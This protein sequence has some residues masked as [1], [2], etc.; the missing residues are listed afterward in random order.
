[1]RRTI[2]SN[3]AALY[4]E[5][6]KIRFASWLEDGY[7]EPKAIENYDGRGNWG[8]AWEGP[9]EWAYYGTTGSFAYAEREPEFGITLPI[10]EIPSKLSHV[11][12]EPANSCVVMLYLA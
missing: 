10:V 4:V 12:S 6:V 1:M 8:I 3:D 5:L 11:F 7:D 9:Y 2:T